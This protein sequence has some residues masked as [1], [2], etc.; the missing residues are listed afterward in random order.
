MFQDQLLKTIQ[1]SEKVNPQ[2]KMT[3]R[4]IIKIQK[5]KRLTSK[6]FLKIHEA[7]WQSGPKIK[8]YNPEKCKKIPH[9]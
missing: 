7:I 4:A 8:Y 2:S 9:T 6:E 3:N 1:K 5:R